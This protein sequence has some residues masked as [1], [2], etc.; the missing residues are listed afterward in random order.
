LLY[1]QTL[2]NTGNVIGKLTTGR[3]PPI[4]LTSSTQPD[5]TLT[6]ND[7]FTTLSIA[8]ERA[9]ADAQG[10]LHA[11]STT[12]YQPP[13][14]ASG[15]FSATESF[16]V[17]AA[18]FAAGDNWV[19]IASIDA[20]SAL[21]PVESRFHVKIN[22]TPPTASSTSHTS[23]PTWYANSN[24]YFA[25]TLPTD[26]SSVKRVH[27]VVDHFGDTVPTLAATALAT[28]QKQLLVSN[29]ADG[30]W[31]LHVVAEDTQGHL[32]KK[33]A[34]VVVRVGADPGSGTVFG[35]VFDSSNHPVAN[36]AVR[37]NRGLFTATTNAQ[38]SYTISGVAAGTWEISVQGYTAAPQMLT[39]TAGNQASANF[40]V[41]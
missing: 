33:A 41:N 17:M 3:R 8:H 31:V 5:P 29:V 4:D 18:K 7:D 39:V 14:P 15:T 19:H 10:Y 6:Y 30:I 25:W 28:S 16:D 13:V 35:S 12:E 23:S 27:Y 40:T 20:D 11:V 38:G 22:T 24:Q 9:F 32:T 26:D 37:V 1:G 2:T 36:A 21:S 34:H